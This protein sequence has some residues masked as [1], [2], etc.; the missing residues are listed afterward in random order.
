M[1]RSRL[2]VVIALLLAVASCTT[3]DASDP[4]S[5]LLPDSDEG[6]GRLV[7]LDDGGDI[8]TMD[9]DGANPVAIT[10]DG[11]STRYFQPVW[12]PRSPRLAWGEGV[13]DVVAVGLAN[14]DGTE[15]ISIPLEGF[16]FYLNWAP[17]SKRVGVLHN[18]LDGSI[19]FEVVDLSSNSAEVIDNGSP[20]YFSWS[21]DSKALVVHAEGDR[22]QILDESATPT[23]LGDVTANFLAPQWT[24]LGILYVG[25]SGLVLRSSDGGEDVVVGA[26]G[27]VSINP[28][29]DGSKV[30]L[31]VL[32]GEPQGLTVALRAQETVE[33]NA[34][35]VVDVVS[36]EVEL[37]SRQIPV[38]AFWSPDGRRLLVLT[39]NGQPGLV[40][41]V[42]WDEGGVDLVDTLELSSS[43]INQVLP[44]LDQYT[45]SIQLW[46]PDSRS[47]ALPGTRAGQ[48]GIWVYPDQE[49][50]P[51]K[52]S[53][54][55]W[56]SW[57]S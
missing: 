29:R 16:P 9:P 36:G 15:R 56:V 6:P 2:P 32:S 55:D 14:N 23:D 25:P 13:D 57:S 52:V 19:D 38:G 48:S 43:M 17:D 12:S 37:V 8:I 42:V 18:G 27:F 46:S 21:P 3:G 45:Q 54:G 31:L 33:S 5:T 10:D 11:T 7:V 35:S 1:A 40:D 49:T 50:E 30:G 41:V 24:E 28:N 53:D 22:L 26:D 34:A 51:T 44:F 20:Y 47:F 4:P 39:L